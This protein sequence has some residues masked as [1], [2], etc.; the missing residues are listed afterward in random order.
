MKKVIGSKCHA[1]IGLVE[2]DEEGS[3]LLQP[4]AILDQRQNHLRQ[5]TIQEVLVQWKDTLLEDATQEP[6]TI[7]QQ[8]PH[9]FFFFVS[10]LLY[11]ILEKVTY[12]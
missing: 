3:I 7:L 6:T 11:W 2:L 10:W 9:L 12:D 8:F 1:Q 5:C 4:Q